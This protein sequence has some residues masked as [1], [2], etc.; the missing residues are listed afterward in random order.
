MDAGTDLSMALGRSSRASVDNAVALGSGSFADRANT[1]SVGAASAYTDAVGNTLPSQLRQ[2]V[3]M[4]AGTQATDAVNVSQLQ[5]VVNA[6][7]GGAA[8]DSTTGAVTGPSY[9]LTNANAIAGTTGAAGDV[10]TGFNKVDAALGALNTNIDNINNG[11]AGLVQQAGAGADL[12]VGKG[13]DG[14]AVDFADKSGNTRTLKNVTAGVADTDAVNMSQL[15]TTNANVANNT[16]AITNINGKL[17]D[18]VIYDSPA[19]DSVTLGGAGATAPVA[20]HNVADGALSATSKDAVNGSQLYATNQQVSQNT[21]DIANISNNINNGSLGL[22][23]QDATTRKITVAKDTDGTVVDV[24]GTEGDRTVTG[25]KSGVAD[26]DAVNVS[27]LKA[28]GLIDSNGNAMNAVVYDSPAMNSVTFG[29]PNAAGPV[30]L[31]NV[32]AGVAGTDA[33]NVNQLNAIQSQVT[34]LDGRVTNIENNGGGSKPIPY[35]D[36]NSGAS[37]KANANAGDSAGVAVGYNSNASGNNASVFGQNATAAGSYGTAVGNDSYAAGANDTALG[38]NA[39]VNADGSVAVGAGATVTS[40]SATNAVAVGAN[41]QVSAASG[42]AVGQG[43]SVNASATNAVALGQG[44]VADRANTV[45]V[46]SAGNQRQITNVQAGVQ[47]TDAVNVS[48][49]QG[50][51]SAI[52]GGSTV[53]ASGNVTAPTYNVAGNSYN[54]VGD[55]MSGLDSK[56]N[57]DFSKLNSSINKVNQQAR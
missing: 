50:V 3:N 26:N 6:L 35:I 12:T 17:A 51:T 16:T 44:S 23:Q 53:D 40:A 32:A 39:K 27:Q 48:Q 1:V 11:S 18:A 4:A 10:G 49:L 9:A 25:V 30:V 8:L 56:L 24:T 34:N 31:H 42:T 5:P 15:N 54:N 33:V 52:G 43:A 38:G 21:N 22:V 2:V 29:G 46:G 41:S 19:H 55:A 57:D 47:Q 14:A 13:T 28:S 20:L 36:G 45:S 37:S 7:G